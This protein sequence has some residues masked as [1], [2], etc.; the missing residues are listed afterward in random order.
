MLNLAITSVNN[1]KQNAQNNGSFSHHCIHI[2][3]FAKITATA[4][5][6]VRQAEPLPDCISTE[7]INAMLTI[8]SNTLNAV[9]N[10]ASSYN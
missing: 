6:S 10:L 7:P 5:K 3:A 8:T 9:I 4:A 2:I 1:G